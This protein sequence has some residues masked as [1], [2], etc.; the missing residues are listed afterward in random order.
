MCRFQLYRACQGTGA[1]SSA[2]TPRLLIRGRPLM[3]QRAELNNHEPVPCCTGIPRLCNTHELVPCCTGTAREVDEVLEA[4]RVLLADDPAQSYPPCVRQG[5]AATRTSYFLP[6]GPACS[7]HQDQH[8]ALLDF[9]DI[10]CS[11]REGETSND[12]A[13][14]V[15]KL[16]GVEIAMQ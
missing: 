15:A 9:Q 14:A 6:P 3:V 16:D 5:W 2:A 8:V 12:R 7:C 11:P 1:R 13:R 10:R 4:L